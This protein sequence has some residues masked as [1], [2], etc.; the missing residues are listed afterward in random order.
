MYAFLKVKKIQTRSD[1]AGVEGEAALMFAPRRI[2]QAISF[3]LID[4][5]I[6]RAID[7]DS[8]ERST[9]DLSTANVLLSIAREQWVH[10]D[11]PQRLQWLQE[12]SRVV[13]A[14]NTDGT[15]TLMVR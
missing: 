9:T 3:H 4:E 2:V 11:N 5:G 14:A 10:M 6:F 7:A 15:A 12:Q 8:C 1:G 13:A